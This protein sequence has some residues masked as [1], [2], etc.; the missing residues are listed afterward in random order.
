MIMAGKSYEKLGLQNYAFNC[1]TI[2]HPFYQRHKGWN[3]I[4]FQLYST[5]GRNSQ[6]MGDANLTVK[7]LRNLLQLCCEFEHMQEQKN[8]LN[9]FL[10]AVS[11]LNKQKQENLIGLDMGPEK[12]K[13]HI[14]Q[15]NL[16]VVMEDSIE[17]FISL[18]KIYTNKSDSMINQMYLSYP[19][20]SANMADEN[21]DYTIQQKA[22]FNSVNTPWKFLG[23]HLFEYMNEEKRKN[24]DINPASSQFN[25]EEINEFAVFDCNNRARK[26]D[27]TM[28]K[29]RK[30]YVGETI[31]V[32]LLIRN[33]L[34]ADITINSMKLVCK[35]LD[36]PSPNDSDM[37]LKQI[38]VML[39]TLETKEI[40]L[41]IIP[42]KQGH[43]II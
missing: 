19:A 11:S 26:R 16:P 41:E 32:K 5:L 4:R 14:G 35:Y 1:F 20:T 34:M 2:V 39:K 22:E 6:S 9:E 12:Y 30:V 13:T 43:L 10:L 23:K 40:I 7:F 3:G 24:A 28:K 25:G 38:D 8:C 37:E 27:L 18:E 21:Q 29:V 36:D 17:V 31:T 33:P 15:L 42:L